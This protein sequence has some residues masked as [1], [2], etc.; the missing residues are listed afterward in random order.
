MS[1]RAVKHVAKS[2]PPRILVVTDDELLQHKL[3]RLFASTAY[4]FC[5]KKPAGRASQELSYL[6]D[7]DVVLLDIS[8][9]LDELLHSLACLKE[10]YPKTDVVLLVSQSEMYFWIEAIHAGAWECLPKPVEGS[11]LEA[12][13][14]MSIN[15]R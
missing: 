6:P 5:F 15:A 12:V 7:A 10:R 11:E 13:V 3:S 2:S 4:S 8:T 14:V 1:A 9:S